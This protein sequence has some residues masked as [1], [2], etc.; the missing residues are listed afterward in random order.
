M[1]EIEVGQILSL[2]I[3]FNNSGDI[4]KSKH[5]YLVINVN[6]KFNFVE[7]AQID[8]LEGKEHKALFKSNKVIFCTDPNE[9]VID[10][11]SYIIH[12]ELKNFQNYLRFAVKMIN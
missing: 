9:T 1:N 5:P 11:D 8:S 6:E 4:S 10:K 2:R 12:S 3:R 7:I